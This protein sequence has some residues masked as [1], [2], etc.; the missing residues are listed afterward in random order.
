MHQF[1]ADQ[2]V[3]FVPEMVPCRAAPGDYKVLSAMPDR[4]GYRVYRIKSPLE[5]HERVVEESLLVKSNGYLPEIKDRDLRRRS[6]TLP[7]LRR[8]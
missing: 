3:T 5:E 1:K 2:V 8:A 6:I 7:A 4:D